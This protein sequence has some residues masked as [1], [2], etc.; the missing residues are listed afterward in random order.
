MTIA[1]YLALC[2]EG[3]SAHSFVNAQWAFHLGGAI[4]PLPT[5][6]VSET[7]EM[8]LCSV[9]AMIGFDPVLCL[10][11]IRRT[12]KFAWEAG[13]LVKPSLL[14]HEFWTVLV[15]SLAARHRSKWHRN[16]METIMH[17]PAWDL[18]W[19]QGIEYTRLE[20]CGA[21]WAEYLCSVGV[22]VRVS[23][24]LRLRFLI[25]WILICCSNKTPAG[26][27]T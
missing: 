10:I 19:R 6:M 4:V 23:L 9:V 20:Y 13:T 27:L 22:L 24:R 26:L 17:S 25:C 5:A 2:S 15:I 12:T 1:C 14:T 7:F 3:R 18:G 16:R 11:L 8:G 21:E